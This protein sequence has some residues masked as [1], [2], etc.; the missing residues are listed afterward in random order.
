MDL[1]PNAHRSDAMQT[2]KKN[3]QRAITLVGSALICVGSV[4]MVI[5]ASKTDSGIRIA[6]SV[7]SD[8]A[9]TNDGCVEPWVR[10]Q[11]PFAVLLTFSSGFRR[12]EADFGAV[13]TGQSCGGAFIAPNWVL[14]AAHCTVPF[15]GNAKLQNANSSNIISDGTYSI[16]PD[17]VFNFKDQNGNPTPP[18]NS[19]AFFCRMGYSESC[20]VMNLPI[21]S[22]E[23]VAAFVATHGTFSADQI[24]VHPRW[25]K[26]GDVL[27]NDIALVKLNGPL[28]KFVRPIPIA[29]SLHGRS[30]VN[31][32][33]FVTATAVG[34]GKTGNPIKDATARQKFRT[35]D[36]EIVS[37]EMYTGSYPAAM[38]KDKICIQNA[39]ATICPGDSGCPLL[40]AG[41]VV[42]VV[43]DGDIR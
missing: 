7:N 19:P 30:D 26:E 12:T 15:H 40:V 5:C 25:A 13:I 28:P 10:E 4:I 9:C 38:L 32:M 33:L 14:T 16:A 2:V 20:R 23:Q 11:F 43:S 22:N 37:C 36:A 6:P 8:I 17:R 21:P 29:R 1:L 3:W 31:S 41:T 42:G 18:P 34:W 39:N 27:L 24:F 35:F